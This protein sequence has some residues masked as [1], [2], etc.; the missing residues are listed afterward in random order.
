MS[1]NGTEKVPLKIKAS[2][3]VKDVKTHWKTP[4]EGRYVPY[5]EYLHIFAAVG[6]NYAN[7]YLL[8]FLSFGVG[9]TLVSFYYEIPMLTFTVINGLFVISGYIW[10]IL[11]M[12]V[13]ANLGFLPKKTEKKYFTLYLTVAALGLIMLVFDLSTILPIPESIKTFVSTNWEALGIN[14]FSVFKL[15]GIHLFVSGW[16]GFRAIIIRK[17]LVPKLGRYKIFAYTNVVQCVVLVILICTLP[18]YEEPLVDRVWK[19]FVLFQLYGMY[20]FVGS[21]QSI[22]DNISPN[23]HER[24]LVRCLPVKISHLFKSPILELIVP[25][26][27]GLLFPRGI[28][29]IGTFKYLIPVSLILCTVLMFSGLGKIQERIPAPPVEKKKYFSFWECVDGIFKNKY[30][31]I[32]QITYLL[33]SLGNGMIAIK[34]ILIVYTWRETGFWFSIAS[35]AIAF[36]GNPG[37]FL[38]PWIR[39][40]FQ[41]KTLYIFKQIVMFCASGVYMLAFLFLGNSS[42]LCGTV[43]FIALC[44]CDAL[45][46]AIEIAAGDMDIR[47]SDYQMYISGERFEGYQ[48]I[49]G[50]FTSP[51]S[52]LIGLIIPLIF[53]RFG[54]TSDWDVL[55]IDDVRIKCM[56]VGLAFDMVGFVLMTLPY[57]FFWDYTD[58]KHA[59]VM[60]VLQERADAAKAAEIVS[61]DISDVEPVAVSAES[62]VSSE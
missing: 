18:L 59:E 39:K 31:W 12:G 32:R 10:S 43:I 13:D 51:I 29:D 28:N 34:T 30:L 6:G 54:F 8:G 48:G 50:W 23:P 57:L 1:K 38:A 49:V 27:A 37:T 17:K 25:T 61:D 20:G 56:F 26:V 15:I 11:S 58:E 47:I 5:K 41:Y 7:A 3:L 45:K 40:R 60:R 36:V 53:Y 52:S 4:A 55:Y 46:S 21:P 62:A 14:L 16:G 44:T 35:N 22:A 19:L 2:N 24:M 33:D 9:C 42:A